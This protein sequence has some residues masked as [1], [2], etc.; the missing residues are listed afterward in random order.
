MFTLI[1]AV[2][3]STSLFSQSFAKMPVVTNCGVAGNLSTDDTATIQA[4]I[5]AAPDGSEV[6]FPSGAT[7]KITATI[8][9]HNRYGL[10]L[11]GQTG[12]FGGPSAGT[13]APCFYWFGPAGGTMFDYNRCDNCVTQGLLFFNASGYIG[14]AG[15][16]NVAINVDQTVPPPGTETA[17]LFERIS[18]VSG[19]QNPAFQAIV[20]AQVSGNNIEAMTVRDSFI[21]CSY[22]A[23]VGQGIVIGPG[24]FYNAKRH[25]YQNNTISNCATDIYLTGG[26][27]DILNNHFNLSKTNVYAAAVDP[28]SITGNDS[29]NAA[30]FFTGPLTAP[31]TMSDNRIAAVSPPAGQAAV[32]ITSGG[33]QVLTFQG[34]K[35]DSGTFMPVGFSSANT[36]GYLNSSGNT[37]PYGGATVAGFYTVPYGLTSSMDS[38]V[39]TLMTVDGGHGPAGLLVGG[40]YFHHIG[41][42]VYDDGSQRWKMSN[43]VSN[44]ADSTGHMVVSEPA[45]SF[46]LS[47]TT[48]ALGSCGAANDLTSSANGADVTSAT[49]SF[50][51]S[52][53]GGYIHV[54]SGN[55]WTGG[56]Y[57]ITNAFRVAAISDAVPANLTGGSFTVNRGRQVL[58]QGSP[59][60][61]DTFWIC[62]QTSKGY[63][64]KQMF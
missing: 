61:A 22:G 50:V 48:A 28:I 25:L 30:Q 53:I 56:D 24:G 27:A 39:S 19:T 1:L 9:L 7:M 45:A 12:R 13:P 55:G 11:L 3:F 18:V 10:R 29:E 5:N 51:T 16:A 43:E 26:S 41:G 34:N 52:D 8:D 31:I 47:G 4:C 23:E 58:L 59:G 63:A 46:T 42:L 62:A 6:V 36:G 44:A 57:Y 20:F 54:N 60:E 33:G 37:Y 35:F 32:W 40:G 2:L 21:N 15:G 38:Y 17:N 14:G 49:I 64:W